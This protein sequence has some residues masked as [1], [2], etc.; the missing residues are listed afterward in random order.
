MKFSIVTPVRNGEKWIAETIKS[1]AT[2]SGN[3][4]IEYLILDGASTDATV[5]I[6]EQTLEEISFPARVLSSPDRGM[7]D[8]IQKGFSQ[9]SGE[10]M[11]WINAG[12]LYRENTFQTVATAFQNPSIDW[13]KGITSYIDESG[14]QIEEG[15]FRL[16]DQKLIQSGYYGRRGPFIQQDSVFWRRSLWNQLDHSEW[17]QY[18]LA[19]D[20]TLWCRFADIAPLTSIDQEL[21][22]FRYHPGQL[23]SQF[24]A[25]LNECDQFLCKRQSRPVWIEKLIPKLD[26]F[27]R[28]LAH[29]AWRILSPSTRVSYWQRETNQNWKL[30]QG[31]SLWDY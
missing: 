28:R 11:A 26:K 23:S 17:H 30:H 15:R 24:A 31:T 1:V 14:K 25:Y 6:A 21:S 10:I 3:F 27:P 18:K 2:Q 13:I 20:F 12:D 5:R 8:A 16:F 4:E 19:G 22:V 9:T 29:S 7:Y